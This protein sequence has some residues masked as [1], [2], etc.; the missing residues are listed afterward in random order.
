MAHRVE[1]CLFLRLLIERAVAARQ[2]RKLIIP[3]EPVAS[4]SYT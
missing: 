4:D 1:G 2:E 3:P